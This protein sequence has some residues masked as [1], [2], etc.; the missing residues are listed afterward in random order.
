[1]F[2]VSTYYNL[3]PSRSGAH[4]QKVKE[5]MGNMIRKLALSLDAYNLKEKVEVYTQAVMEKDYT[6]KEVKDTIQSL[7]HQ[8]KFPTLPEFLNTA[9]RLVGGEKEN[10]KRVESDEQVNKEAIN[11]Q[12]KTATYKQKFIEKYSEEELHKQ[13]TAWYEAIYPNCD[14]V[15]FNCGLNMFLPVFFQDL[16]EGKNG[17]DGAIKQG[18]AK[19]AKHEGKGN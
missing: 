12:N 10:A 6:L 5:E 11:L 3:K 7:S 1:M 17:L 8:S 14:L 19:K 15:K 18:L 9:S 2:G 4:Y 16:I 13:L